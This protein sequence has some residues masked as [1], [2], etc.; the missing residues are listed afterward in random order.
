MNIYSEKN[1]N[2]IPES[3]L[4]ITDIATWFPEKRITSKDLQKEI[5]ALDH[6]M[7]FDIR[8]R[9]GISE[10]RAASENES[11][12]DMAENAARAVLKKAGNQRGMNIND[13]DTII[14]GGMSRMYIEPSSAPLLQK[15]LGIKKAYSLDIVNACLGVLDGIILA[16]SFVKSGM[17]E[18]VLIVSAERPSTIGETILNAMKSG[19]HGDECLAAMTIGDGAVGIIASR[20]KQE[21]R[22]LMKVIAYSRVNLGEHAECSIIPYDSLVFVTNSKGIVDGALAN[23]PGLILDMLKTVNWTVDDVDALVVHQ[24]SVSV[25]NRMADRVGIPR[26]KCPITCD[27]FGNTGTVSA[28][29]T[30][31]SAV[32]DLKLQKGNKVIVCGIGAGLGFMIMAIEIN[33]PQ[34]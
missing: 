24:M 6:I 19:T 13:I 1:A 9:T 17:S 10:R 27:R 21:S 29:H 18:N 28:P 31:L 11:I 3:S 2:T 4:E 25:T 14:Y 22:A 30:L 8:E 32:E 7:D 20:K 5:D 34:G 15:K 26:E 23:C 12:I 33:S 16:D